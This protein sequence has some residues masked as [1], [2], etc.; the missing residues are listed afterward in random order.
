MP[1][2]PDQPPTVREVRAGL[3]L[4]ETSLSALLTL[5]ITAPSSLAALVGNGGLVASCA[6]ARRDV[7][8]ALTRL[9]EEDP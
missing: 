6:E 9:A 3:A 5:V 2:S 7:R 1:T 4:A 8:V